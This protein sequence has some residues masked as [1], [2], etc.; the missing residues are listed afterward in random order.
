M[1]FVGLFLLMFLHLILG[2]LSSKTNF[3]KIL[4]I[5]QS[6]VIFSDGLLQYSIKRYKVLRQ[7]LCLIKKNLFWMMTTN[8]TSKVTCSKRVK[9]V[10]N[11]T[12]LICH[13]RTDFIDYTSFYDNSCC[14]WRCRE[15]Q[16][17]FGD[18][19]AQAQVCKGAFLEADFS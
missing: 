13:I 12:K 10:V 7:G 14:L 16:V 17:Q 15:S 2:F 18:Q 3:D 11:N 1:L 8:P 19:L 5:T 4:Q 9:F 6:I